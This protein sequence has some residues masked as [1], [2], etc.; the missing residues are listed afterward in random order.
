M[1]LYVTQISDSVTSLALASQRV[2]KCK[3]E[4]FPEEEDLTTLK[5]YLLGKMSELSSQLVRDPTAQEWRSLAEV[6][7]TRVIVFNGRR[8]S[9]AAQLLVSEYQQRNNDVQS[10]VLNSVS[11]VEKHLISRYNHIFNYI[12]KLLTVHLMLHKPKL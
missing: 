2:S 11:T 8:G 12:Q 9:E 6:T 10:D 4:E 5:V 3:L 7:L 1:H